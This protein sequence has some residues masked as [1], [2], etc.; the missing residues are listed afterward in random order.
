MKRYYLSK[1]KT[2]DEGGMT[3]NRHR[4]QEY[5]DVTY[6]GGE[7]LVDP[8]TG[9][10]V[11][12]SLLVLVSDKD[13]VKFDNDPEL[14]PLP[15]IAPGVKVGATDIATKMRF[16]AKAVALGVAQDEIDSVVA[17][18]DGWAD[19]LDHFGRKNNPDFS[20]LKFDVDAQ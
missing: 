4:I 13:H 2:V 7:I 12:G 14:A 6:E 18:A 9:Q 20:H 19:V 5:K 8:Q 1:I 3:I 17:N 11:H 15:L 16:K 10:P